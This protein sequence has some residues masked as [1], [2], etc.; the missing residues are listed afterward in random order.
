MDRRFATRARRAVSP[1]KR[2]KPASTGLELKDE[3]AFHR[4]ERFARRVGTATIVAL[5]A[6]AF[7]GLFGGGP[8]SHTSTRSSDGTVQVFHERF[9]RA[10]APAALRIVLA[11]SSPSETTARLW[12]DR[13]FV[14]GIQLEE[15]LPPAGRG[16]MTP[17]R[18]VYELAIEPS[19]TVELVVRYRAVSLGSRVVRVGVEGHGT[20]RF[21]Q[22][23]FP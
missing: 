18:V 15:F 7:V 12:L 1:N 23:V 20:T 2:E 14:R 17:D 10:N 6:P 8:L 13:Q 5:L 19:D 21:R 11:P 22:F 3:P 9:G 4:R 16:R